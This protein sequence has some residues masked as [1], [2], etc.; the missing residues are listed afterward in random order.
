MPSGAIART[1]QDPSIGR[2][3]VLI[4]LTGDRQRFQV[5]Q[6]PGIIPLP[7]AA[8]DRTLV[9]ELFSH[10]DVVGQAFADGRG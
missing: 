1:D 10:G 5:A 4:D 6:P 9:E 2:P 3:I 7:A 8:G